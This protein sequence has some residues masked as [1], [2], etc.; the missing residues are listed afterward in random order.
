L[1]PVRYFIVWFFL[2]RPGAG[3][4]DASLAPHR[5]S[6][7]LRF[8]CSLISGDPQTD[9]L[10]SALADQIIGHLTYVKTLLSALQAQFATQERNHY[11]RDSQR[12]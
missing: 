11:S 12:I 7:V 9:F 1:Q 3:G 5:P 8:C 2:F 6:G 4:A 10:A